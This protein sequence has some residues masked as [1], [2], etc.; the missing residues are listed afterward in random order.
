MQERVI[1]I[2]GVNKDQEH[3][4]LIITLRITDPD[5][6]VTE[7][8]GIPVVNPDRVVCRSFNIEE[9]ED[10]FR[11][12]KQQQKYSVS[13]NLDNSIGLLW[14]EQMTNRKLYTW[15]PRGRCVVITMRDKR[16]HN[17]YI[18][19]ADATSMHKHIQLQTVETG[20]KVLHF[21]DGLDMV[22]TESA[23]QKGHVYEKSQIQI[24]ARS[25]ELEL[26]SEYG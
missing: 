10:V 2:K 17:E 1:S 26:Q 18:A 5:S 13:R 11:N 12:H 14:T 7:I 20:Y 19:V 24:N 25:G 8:L 15:F 6:D 9:S 16:T 22:Y 23:F 21:N 3:G 4:D